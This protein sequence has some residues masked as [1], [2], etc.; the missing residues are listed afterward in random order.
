MVTKSHSLE[1]F[2]LTRGVV[3][4]HRE[5]AQRATKVFSL[6]ETLFILRR[7]LLTTLRI[8]PYFGHEATRLTCVS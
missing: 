3:T 5:S 6:R 2:S 7:L 8:L 1:T 4:N